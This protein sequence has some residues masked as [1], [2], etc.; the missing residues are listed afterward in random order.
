MQ[1]QGMQFESGYVCDCN[2]Y[3]YIEL[4]I[5]ISKRNRTFA[6][7]KLPH[8]SFKCCFFILLSNVSCR[9]LK[10]MHSFLPKKRKKLENTYFFRD[11]EK[12][13]LPWIKM[14]LERNYQP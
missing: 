5:N 11:R 12:R 6:T 3:I 8:I 9:K 1:K 7:S 4:E 10:F 14:S 13:V 2:L